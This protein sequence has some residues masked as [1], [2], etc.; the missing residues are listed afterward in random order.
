MVLRVSVYKPQ[1]AE[2]GREWIAFDQYVSALRQV[3]GDKCLAIT[4]M[5]PNTGDSGEKC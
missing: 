2:R 3:K 5:A 4:Y 1:A